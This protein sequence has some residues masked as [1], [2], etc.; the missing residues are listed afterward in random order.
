M[1]GGEDTQKKIKVNLSEPLIQV[2]LYL[3]IFMKKSK[4]RISF[5]CEGCI[6]FLLLGLISYL[7][8]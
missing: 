1:K 6:Q 8:W 2:D 7:A 5:I 4:E 3:Q